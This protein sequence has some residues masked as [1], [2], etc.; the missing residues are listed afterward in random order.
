MNG[1]RKPIVWL[2]GANGLPDPPFTPDAQVE[3]GTLL[4]LLQQGESLG[5]P[6]S[7]PMPD[8]GPRCHELR[9]RDADRSWRI[10]YRT[11][12]DA[13]IV[14]HWFPK[15]TRK[16]PGRIIARCRTVLARYDAAA[17]PAA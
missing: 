16:T 13:I 15:T 9:V 6:H 1:G 11:D 8:I 7:R 3:A 10:I 17:G 2:A 5:M 12:P 14:V 4:R